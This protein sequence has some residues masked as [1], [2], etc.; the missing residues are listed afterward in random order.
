MTITVD[1]IYE[2]GVLKPAEALPLAEHEHVEVTIH[3]PQGAGNEAKSSLAARQEALA[4]LC[5]LE[6]PVSDWEAMEDE[7]I[8]G[9]IE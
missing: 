3:A 5:S 6:L 1:A 7:I 8:R 2:N 9:A 4:A